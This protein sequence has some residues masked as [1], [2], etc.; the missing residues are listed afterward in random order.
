MSAVKTAPGSCELRITGLDCA[1]CAV[2]VAQSLRTIPGVVDA[3]VHFVKGAAAISYDPERVTLTMLSKRITSLGYG[4]ETP[5]PKRASSDGRWTFTI[6]GMDCGDCAKTI[7]A[8]VQVLPGV[9][10]ATV[11][12]GSGSMT[13]EADRER[14][15][16]D[17]VVQVV[18]RAGY[19]ATLRS[20]A[21]TRK[22]P[23]AA[24]AWWRQRRINEV[25]VAAGLWL[26]GFVLEKA[27]APRAVNAIPFLIGMLIGGYPIARAGWFALRARRADMNLLM[28]VAAIG[29]V[30][31]GQ[32]EEGASVLTLF[33]VAQMLQAMTLDRTRRSIEGLLELAP[34]EATVIRAGSELRLPVERVDVGEIVRVRPGERLPVDGVVIAGRSDVDQAP[35]TGES[36]PVYVEDGSTVYAGSI[37]GDGALDVRSTKLASDTTLA[38]IVHLVEEA[39]G[40]KAPA[41]ALVDRFAALYT[42]L[43]I[44]GAV[45]VALGPPLFVG[46]WWGWIYKA[47]VLLV[48]ACPCALVI[49]TPVAL[50]A[51]IGSGSRN[52]ILFKG[53]AALEALAAVRGVAFDKTGTLTIGRPAVVAIH[54]RNGHEEA[55]VLEVAAALEQRSEHPLAR[56]ILA[57][58]RARTF[59]ILPVDDFM[60]SPGRGGSGVVAGVAASVGSPRWFTERG[61]W[62]AAGNDVFAREGNAIVCVESGGEMIGLLTLR[63]TVRPE[64]ARAVA[65]LRSLTGTV[66]M[67]SGDNAATAASIAEQTGVTTVR[68]DL[69][70]ADKVEAV[71]ELSARGPMAMVGDGINDAPALATASVGIAMGAAGTD[72]AIEAADVALMSDDLLALPFAIRLARKTMRIIYQNIAASV[73]VKALFLALTFIGITNLWLAVLADMGMSLLVTANALRLLHVTRRGAHEH[74]VTAN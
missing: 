9:H 42:P 35:I 67:L 7:G 18:S 74:R 13:V 61:L 17:D 11:N 40:S 22:A 66:A 16:P 69:L 46:D 5:A 48:I 37:N 14:V 60:A 38:R 24:P 12:F 58:A 72:V 55:R 63:D 73:G 64:S 29:A 70:P 6:S 2:T 44:V 21:T 32:W 52:G 57:E 23:A 34:A 71:R 65:D 41:Q 27:G 19:S 8:G 36:T 62:H 31:I 39:Q 43:V 45:A 3:N 51:A 59:T 1:D 56:A 15:T 28:T 50:V 53:G 26:V 33:A 25:G 68:A 49:S 20:S 10:A 54:P 30:I 47:L 4:V